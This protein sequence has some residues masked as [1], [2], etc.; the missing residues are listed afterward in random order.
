MK[1]NLLKPK[2]R[3]SVRTSYKISE[4]VLEKL[5]SLKKFYNFTIKDIID[6]FISHD[7]MI[8]EAIE[9]IKK[10]E[11]K[12]I[13]DGTRKTYVISKRT[14]CKIDKISKENNISKD[15][16]ITYVILRFHIWHEGN[17]KKHKFAMEELIKFEKDFESFEK[18][19]STKLP[20]DDPIS[21]G[22]SYIY[23][24]TEN[25]INAIENEI[26]NNAPINI[27]DL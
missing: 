7:K 22:L 15:V 2:S 9:M 1:N 17:M 25:L 11:I 21:Y 13:I 4:S 20:P 5:G 16:L 3:E 18:K 27:E 24:I 12:K 14:K 19:L 6:S 23:N 10:A 8:T 26:E